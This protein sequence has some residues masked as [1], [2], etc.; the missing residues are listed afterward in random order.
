MVVV[1]RNDNHGG[2][3]HGRMQH[4]VNG[5]FAQCRRHK[6]SAE[7]IMV[8][9][10]PPSDR[11]SLSEALEW[12]SDMGPAYVRIVTVPREIHRLLK[13]SDS[14]PLFQMIG[15]NVGVRRARGRYI[16]ATNIDILMNGALICYMRDKLIPN[17]MVRVDR[18]D[19]PADIPHDSDFNKVIEFCDNSF[20]RIA[21]AHGIFEPNSCTFKGQEESPIWRRAAQQYAQRLWPDRSSQRTRLDIRQSIKLL[22]KRFERAA[23]KTPWFLSKLWPAQRVPIRGYWFAR[24][25]VG[26]LARVMIDSFHFKVWHMLPRMPAATNRGHKLMRFAPGGVLAHL[27]TNACGD[28]TLLTQEDWKRLRGYPEWPMYSWH[29]DSVFLCLAARSGIQQIVLPPHYRTYHIE[30]DAGSGWTPEEES[31]L[32]NRLRVQGVPYLSFEELKL[33]GQ[34]CTQGKGPSIINDEN[35]GLGD[36]DLSENIIRSVTKDVGVASP[37]SFNLAQP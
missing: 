29:I 26:N 31:K 37:D 36:L 20:F 16:L 15:K 9:W 22:A 8:E 2:D 14:L 24:Q 13:Y 10:N 28:F 17:T 5:F 35:W 25:M 32:F 1:S 19:V 4:F 7:L 6:L 11:P 27:H 12:P 34:R 30:H 23:K 3:M 18:F 33:W 21:T